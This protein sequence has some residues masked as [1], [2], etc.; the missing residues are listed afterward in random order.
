MKISYRLAELI[1]SGQ[2]GIGFWINLGDPGLA[3]L[4]S[5]AGYDWVLVDMEHNPFTETQVQGMIY[6]ASASDVSCIVRV[7]ANVEHDVKWILDSGASGIVIPGI[8]DSKEAREAVRISKYHPLGMRGYGPNRATGFWTHTDQYHARANNGV[9]LICQVELASAVED[10]EA[11]CRVE[12]VDGLWIGPTDLAQSLGHL[13]DPRHPDVKAAIDKVIAAANKSKRPWGIPT[14]TAEDFEQ[15]VKRGG[16]LM[17]LG[18]DTGLL[19]AVATERV[20]SARSAMEGL[21]AR[22]G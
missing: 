4:A 19:K 15:Y 18:S 3:Q 2:P 14:G 5:V 6:A 8:R 22:S 20:K 21:R 9:M 7:R 16:T 11:I 1:A 12:G 17:V 13:G 10:I